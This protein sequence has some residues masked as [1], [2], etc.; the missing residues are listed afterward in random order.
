MRSARV[1]VFAILLGC[2]SAADDFANADVG[3]TDVETAGG[4]GSGRIV[5]GGT[6]P[7]GGAGAGGGTSSVGGAGAKGGAGGSGGSAGG[8]SG[9]A[10]S[11]GAGGSGGSMGL[12]HTV[13]SCTGLA[14]VG[15]WESITPPGVLLDKLNGQEIY[16]T[17]S[18]LVNPQQP[19]IV[20]VGADK[21]GVF[22]S[23]DC[24]ASWTKVNTGRNGATLGSGAQWS[25]AMDPVDPQVIYAVNGYGRELGLWKTTNGG[26]DW[27]QL[28]PPESEV[29]KTVDY[30][31]TSIV[32]M[33]PTDHRHLVVSFHS[34]C[35]GAYAPGCQ[36]ESKDSGA[37]WRLFKGP[38]GSEGGGPIVLGPTT[39]L[40]GAPLDASL[41]RTA[42]SGA[43][44]Q[45]V[46]GQGAHYQSYRAK[47]GTYYIGTGQGIIKSSDGAAWSLIPN[48]S[49]QL[50]GIAGD[51]QSIFVSSQFGGKYYSAPEATATGWKEIATPGRPNTGWGAYW[52]AYDPDHHI[53]YATQ[54]KGGLW[55]V[56]TR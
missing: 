31:F 16:G 45:K 30:N 32:A 46:A 8:I 21:Q 40:Y 39:W 37:T 14:P 53:L 56:V 18:V 11:A 47:D 28:F 51:G 20:Y 42:D 23:T 33:D 17:Q 15:Q 52:M 13:G 25:M 41:Y 48:S 43:T 2:G 36:A 9:G 24:G 1:C 55:R 19:T 54:Q 7:S 22:K 35:K 34:P 29:A 50:T 12:P 6:G 26:V 5:K 44:W 10:G 27:D 4:G 49:G 38:G 3:D